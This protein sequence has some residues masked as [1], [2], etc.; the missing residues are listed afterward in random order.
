MVNYKSRDRD[1]LDVRAGMNVLIKRK[2]V[3]LSFNFNFV[4][5]FCVN[6]IS[7]IVKG[8]VQYTQPSHVLCEMQEVNKI[9]C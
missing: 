4:Y 7:L 9:L 6:G 2:K 3:P 1:G 8:Q 5:S